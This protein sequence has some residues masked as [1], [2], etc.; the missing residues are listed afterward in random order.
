[1]KQ[2]PATQEWLR[3]TR[4]IDT[5]YRQVRD[6][7]NARR[8]EVLK[9]ILY[10]IKATEQKIDRIPAVRKILGDERFRVE[11]LDPNNP[12]PGKNLAEQKAK[13][14]AKQPK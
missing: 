1:M 13:A 12:D 5:Y 4:S 9:Q 7:Y 2:Q 10:T 11:M 3:R 8:N 6:F 14:L